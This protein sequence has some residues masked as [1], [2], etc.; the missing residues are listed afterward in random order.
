[1]LYSVKC[2]KQFDQLYSGPSLGE[3]SGG[4]WIVLWKPVVAAAP[5]I[6]GL[7]TALCVL[8]LGNYSAPLLQ[9]SC[10]QA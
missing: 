6:S 5:G 10:Q 9:G 8:L 2:S 4:N 7:R 1:M 3:L